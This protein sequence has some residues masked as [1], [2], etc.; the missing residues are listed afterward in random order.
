MDPKNHRGPE[1]PK[2]RPA[3]WEVK[4]VFMRS[5]SDAKRV[6][7]HEDRDET[8]AHER[9]SRQPG[10]ARA[11]LQAGATEDLPDFAE[12]PHPDDG[13]DADCGPPHSSGTRRNEQS[14]EHRIAAERVFSG[15][16]FQQRAMKTAKDDERQPNCGKYHAARKLKDHF[17]SEPLGVAREQIAPGSAP[18]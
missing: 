17:Y 7:R 18:L 15:D 2:T 9:G 5:S 6:T 10:T 11:V 14:L 12:R 13:G 3:S 4:T 1:S 16:Q 8:R